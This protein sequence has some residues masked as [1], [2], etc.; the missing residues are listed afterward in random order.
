MRIKSFHSFMSAESG[1]AAIEI[2]FILPFM[3]FMFFGM[4]DITDMVSYNRR[5]TAVASSV[6]DLVGQNRTYVLKSSIDDYLKAAKLI[7]KP[8]S[9]S[10]IRVTIYGFR[11]TTT[12]GVTTVTQE[13][14]IDNGKGA[15]CSTTPS[16]TNVPVALMAAGND[17]IV[18]QACMK[19]K[20]MVADLLGTSILGS[21]LLN[22]EQTITLRP[23]SSLTLDCYLTSTTSGA[24]PKT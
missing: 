16:T 12:G 4:V 24:C 3:F 9:D 6:G 20:P 18:T 17:L 1:V 13:W 8:K 23:R 2:A 10:D 19:Y 5:I 14:K 11:G 22:I 21:S 15:A 7:M